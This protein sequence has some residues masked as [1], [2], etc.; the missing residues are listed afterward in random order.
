[1]KSGD[2]VEIKEACGA[3]IWKWTDI[4]GKSRKGHVTEIDK[5]CLKVRTD[6]GE[7][8]RDVRDHFRPAKGER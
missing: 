2:Y 1:M 7:T 4:R 8:I 5:H 3:G 6:D